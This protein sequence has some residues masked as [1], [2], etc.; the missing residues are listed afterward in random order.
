MGETSQCGRVCCIWPT[1]KNCLPLFSRS[2][3]DSDSHVRLLIY[4]GTLRRNNQPTYGNQ[5]AHQAASQISRIA[6]DML[7]QGTIRYGQ[8]HLYVSI[9]AS[10]GD[11]PPFVVHC[12]EPH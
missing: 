10:C 8:M 6:E 2:L 3:A 4:Q 7:M 9:Q 12:M 11:H 1:S 5:A